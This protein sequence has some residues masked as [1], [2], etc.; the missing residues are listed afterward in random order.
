MSDTAIIILVVLLCLCFGVSVLSLAD[1]SK[2]EKEA[3]RRGYATYNQ[4]GEFVWKETL[5]DR[6]GTIINNAM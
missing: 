1:S 3:V 2:L 4:Q 5:N 6:A